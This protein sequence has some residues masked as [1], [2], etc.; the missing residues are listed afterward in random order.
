MP[1]T[2]TP[3]IDIRKVRKHVCADALHDTVR[4]SFREI[5]DGRQPGSPIT[6]PDAMMSAS[7]LVLAQ[8]SCPAWPSTCAAWR[9][10]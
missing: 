8:R 2:V 5:P 1:A 6:L 3:Q 4:T 10:T 7:A 9:E